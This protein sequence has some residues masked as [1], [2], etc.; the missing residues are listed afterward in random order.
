MTRIKIAMNTNF[1][2]RGAAGSWLTCVQPNPQAK[3]RLFCFPYAGGSAQLYH[4]WAAS[5]PSTV[6]VCP[7]QLPGRGNRMKD[8]PFQHLTPLVKAISEGILPYLNKPFCFFGHSMGAMISFELTRRIRVQYGLQPLHLFVAGRTAPQVVVDEP[9]TYHLPE[10]EFLESLHDLN[11]TPKELLAN[12]ELM[13]LMIPLLRADFEV[14]QTY[15]Y[16]SGPS[17]ECPLTVYGGTQDCHVSLEGY[18][19]WNEQT[20]GPFKLTMFDGDHFFIHSHQQQLLQTLA[21]EL[22]HVVSQGLRLSTS[23]STVC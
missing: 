17:L 9:H 5:L 12:T 14:C 16:V 7:I 23:V 22:D 3:M 4:R 19:A 1:L 18:E 6:E 21:K 20:T 2:K 15:S 10:P 8:A 11:G 13:Q